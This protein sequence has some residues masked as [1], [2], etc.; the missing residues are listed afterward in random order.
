MTF[1]NS[2]L[3]TF[4][5]IL[6]VPNSAI[7]QQKY[8]SSPNP[9]KIEETRAFSDPNFKSVFIPVYIKV[10]EAVEKIKIEQGGFTTNIND[11]AIM[12]D[13]ISLK[14]KEIIEDS[15]ITVDDYKYG[16]IRFNKDKK[17]MYD[18]ISAYQKH[19]KNK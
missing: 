19:K 14:T 2:F 11:F 10:Q 1:K 18:V 3:L 15:P 5:L 4:I 9:V 17:F 12:Q 6:L 13:R 7:S 16:I 8:P